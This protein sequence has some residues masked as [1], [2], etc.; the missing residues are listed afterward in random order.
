M[1]RKEFLSTFGMGLAAICAGGCLASCS[2]SSDTPGG[3]GGG[4]TTPPSG[5][6]FTVDLGNEIRS[7][8]ESVI[9]SG[10][11]VVR[12]AAGATPG[13]FTAVQVACTHQGTPVNFNNGQTRFIC[14]NHGSQ[15]TTEG[16]VLNGPASSNL[17]KYNI[18]ITANTMTVTG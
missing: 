1:D 10:V 13:S 6:N 2:K 5:T 3:G 14:P 8:G 17:K 7:I 16:V 12:L 18:A 4:G 11:I 15:F 9:K